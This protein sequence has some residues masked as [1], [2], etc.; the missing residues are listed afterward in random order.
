MEAALQHLHAVPR[1][2]DRRGGPL[3]PRTGRARLRA[4]FFAFDWFFIDPRYRLT[5]AD[6]AEWVAL[7][8]LL[9]AGIVTGTL[10]ARER[11]RAEEAQERE[12]VAVVIYEVV[13]ALSDPDLEQGLRDVVARV[14][15]ELELEAVSIEVGGD[16]GVDLRAVAGEVESGG[17]ELPAGLTARSSGRAR[18]DGRRLRVHM[19]HPRT[20]SPVGG[21]ERMRVVPV[22]A[23]RRG[24]VGDLVLVL[25]REDRRFDPHEDRL[26]LAVATQLGIAVERARLRE[27]TLD[28][29]VLRRTDELKTA[30]LNAVSHDLRT[31][32][33]SIIA[34][35]GS[36]R[37]T[38]VKWTDDERREFA[39]AI[40]EEGLRLNGIVGNLLDLSRM[41]GGTLRPLKEWYHLG[42]L[43]DD[44]LGRLRPLTAHHPIF[45]DIPANMPP[46]PLD[47]VE[48]DQVLSNLVENATKYTPPG[49]RIQI[50]A[51]WNDDEVRVEVV[52]DGP[53]IP[54]EALPRLFEPFYR[55][56]GVGPKPKGTGLG[57]AV[58]K[59]LVEAHGGRVWS[60][61]P[62]GG[63]A[64]FTFTLPLSAPADT[65]APP[66]GVR[67]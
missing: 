44:V 7:F 16:D 63:G 35:A 54:Q 49:T 31:P 13:H 37:Q 53:G 50:S 26:L 38:D 25:P 20:W 67:G 6:P 64:R 65:T 56:D 57:L 12:R 10:A 32:L 33:A 3:R 60:E 58:T 14:R 9:F 22:F 17:F 47:Y 39:E 43:V 30:L 28:T 51:L 1:C 40:E 24:R 41:E 55:A 36:L 19:P 29:E 5:V 52:D 34:S 23:P 27:E 62:H 48:I 45:V 61:N 59:G 18:A 15:E 8:P 4:A 21:M 11:R 66:A 46:A 2:G 42:A